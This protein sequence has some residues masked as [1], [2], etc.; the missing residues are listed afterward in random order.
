ML[1]HEGWGVDRMKHSLTY[2]GGMSRGFM[3]TYA[4]A[5]SLKFETLS[6]YTLPNV[7]EV[8]EG[9]PF[10]DLTGWDHEKLYRLKGELV[11]LGIKSLTGMDM[12]VFPKRRFQHGAS[13]G[14]T[15]GEMFPEGD[16]VY[17]REFQRIYE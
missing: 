14:K 9:I 17:R 3:R 10:I 11:R 6:P 16:L 7:I 1:Y 13:S 12:P 2:S 4:P 5:D 8:A 15:F